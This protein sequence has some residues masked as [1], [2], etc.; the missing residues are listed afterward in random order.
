MTIGAIVAACCSA[1]QY[2]T[3][4]SCQ[5]IRESGSKQ[6]LFTIVLQ[7]IAGCCSELRC[8]AVCYSVSQRTI[9]RSKKEE[10]TQYAEPA[11][12]VCT[13]DLGSLVH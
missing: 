6:K 8:A 9:L 3:V 4:R 5:Q 13:T 1:L 12:L 10:K 7:G 11:A 2:V